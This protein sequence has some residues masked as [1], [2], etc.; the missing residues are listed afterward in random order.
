MEESEAPKQR[1]ITVQTRWLRVAAVVLVAATVAAVAV[2]V[3]H[4]AAA[5]VP[6]PGCHGGTPTLTEQGQASA[7]GTP[8]TLDFD[9]DIDVNA[10]SAAAALSQ[11]NSVTAAVVAALEA[12]GVAKKDIATTNLSVSPNYAEFHGQSVISGYGVDNSLSVTIRH[13]LSAGNVIDAAASAGGDALSIDSLQFA[14][15][16]PQAL[17]DKAR[18]EAVTQA[19][20]HARSMAA[21]A[22]QRLGSLCRLTDDSNESPVPTPLRL[23]AAGFNAASASS[24]PLEPG[25]QQA[26]AQITIVY[27]LEARPTR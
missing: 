23:P 19:I 7:S 14:L 22:G 13:L 5:A 24:V 3:S 21:A 15:S 18:H 4:G 27:A 25:T 1:V 26:S 16:D 8:R 17:Q 11:D 12:N 10:A 9:A 6:A 2:V 20:S